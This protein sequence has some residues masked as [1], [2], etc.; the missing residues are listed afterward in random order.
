MQGC[1]DHRCWKSAVER[2]FSPIT[3]TAGSSSKK[4]HVLLL[5]LLYLAEQHLQCLQFVRLPGARS[6][7]GVDYVDRNYERE[8]R[9]KTLN[10]DRAAEA[11]HQRSSCIR[12]NHQ[13]V[14]L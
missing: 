9:P 10:P 11:F 13:C 4:D 7:K 1:E 12:K 14:P 6:G 5:E 3:K 8:V 2:E